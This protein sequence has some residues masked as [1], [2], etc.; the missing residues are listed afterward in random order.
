MKKNKFIRLAVVWALGVLIPLALAWRAE[1]SH[2]ERGSG[3]LVGTF[4]IEVQTKRHKVTVIEL[5]RKK[6]LGVSANLV[7]QF[8]KV[9]KEKV[10][11]SVAI[12][13]TG[14]TSLFPP[15]QAVVTR[16]CPV[17]QAAN[18]D[19]GTGPGSWQWVYLGPAL[20]GDGLL[21]PGELSDRKVWKFAARHHKSRLPKSFAID[22]RLYAGI[23][24]Q[25]GEGATITG[26]G[27]V[28][29]TVAPDS[30]PYEAFIAIAPAP[31]GTIVAP[32]GDN[33][34][35]AGAVTL[36]FRPTVPG[37]P[38]P[39]RV[40]L[41]I[42]IPAPAGLPEDSDFVAALQAQVDVP[43]DPPSV[44]ARMI[45]VSR[46]VLAGQ[47]LTTQTGFFPG[48]MGG[49]DYAILRASEPAV[50]GF[51]TGLVSDPLGPRRG[52]VVSNNTNAFVSIADSA[53]RYRLYINGGPFTVSA[54]DP[55]RGSSGTNDGQINFLGDTA[56][57]DITLT[58]P[59]SLS[60]PMRDGV[61]DGGFEIGP[62]FFNFVNW[63]KSGAAFPIPDLTYT[64]T[65]GTMQRIL[66]SEAGFMIDL[67]TGQFAVDQ[68]GSSMS[69]RFIIPAGVQK[70][71]FDY[72]MIS[73]E[74]PEFRGT[75]FNDTFRATL[76]TTEGDSTVTVSINDPGGTIDPLLGDCHF[77]DGDMTCGA[78]GWRTA[79]FDIAPTL[80]T[81]GIRSQATL[82]FS[83]NDEG[84][85]I[86]DTH[87]LI[88]NIRFATLWVD[89]KVLQG[90]TVSAQAN[91]ARVVR[92]VIG[93]N[94]ANGAN[95][96]LAQA[97]VNVRIR[98]VR[99]TPAPN[100][101]LLDTDIEAVSVTSCG[102]GRALR[103][104]DAVRQILGLI[105]SATAT[106]INVYY[107]RSLQRNGMAAAA[108]YAPNPDDFC[109]VDLLTSSGVLL[110][111]ATTELGETM[112]HELGHILISPPTSDSPFEHCSEPT[113][114]MASVCSGDRYSL[115]GQLNRL[116]S[117]IINRSSLLVP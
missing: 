44:A 11:L 83:V 59:I 105:R 16:V 97:G 66:P 93:V 117:V 82:A 41:E 106:D 53:G 74:F 18:A 32:L 6:P 20:G 87:V 90:P 4:R 37:S 72:N 25:P 39:P 67:G 84:D 78:T 45:P 42:A 103:P 22:V 85:S 47:R 24:L 5:K 64:A 51:A 57:V 8:L 49:G 55:F 3:V 34:E 88:D 111:D 96:I 12:E 21:S 107:V 110:G 27:G 7:A 86:F 52:A 95:E 23:P 69:Q 48:I 29:V 10:S 68:V 77:A 15:I 98:D 89:G 112:A 38:L 56:T 114:F 19:S 46:V 102:E 94:G 9:H 54:F 99:N 31:A 80:A 28:S 36:T 104:N 50:K 26:P 109:Q 1:A 65:D 91:R 100:D 62:F 14:S 101:A 70:L 30:I 81:P 75:L 92:E 116:Q 108:G 60:T 63:Q 76:S 13:N 71:Y 73:E 40:P 35:P 61:R 115:A 113:N 2:R 58:T 43:S 33:L 17:V 79:S